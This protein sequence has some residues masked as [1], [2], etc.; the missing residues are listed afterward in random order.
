MELARDYG[1]AVIGDG[2]SVPHSVLLPQL[3]KARRA[4]PIA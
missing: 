1:A 3:A 4:L 2:N